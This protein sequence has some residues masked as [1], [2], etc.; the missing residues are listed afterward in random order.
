MNSVRKHY[1]DLDPGSEK[2]QFF[3]EPIC[4][5]PRKPCRD[6]DNGQ[7]QQHRQSQ[8]QHQHHRPA[9]QYQRHGSAQQHQL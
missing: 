4:L 2:K 6:S 9:K 5:K 8:Q 7:P 3:S 1:L